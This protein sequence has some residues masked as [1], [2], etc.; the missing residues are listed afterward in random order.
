MKCLICEK[1]IEE[2]EEEF[3]QTCKEFFLSQNKGDLK[4]LAN[5]FQETNEF[6]EDWR[7]ESDKK[8]VEE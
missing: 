8:E 2:T 7:S 6:L 5:R 3:C 4:K 1:K